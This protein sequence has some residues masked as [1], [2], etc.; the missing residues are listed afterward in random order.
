MEL[1]VQVAQVV[2]QQ[3]QVLQ[4]QVE[5]MVQMVAQEL[6]VLQ[7]QVVRQ[8]LRV[9]RQLRVLQVQVERQVILQ[10]ILEQVELLKL[11]H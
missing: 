7:V 1:Q 5:L 11:Y 8:V 10:F 2:H 3:V 4:E 6:Q 9:L